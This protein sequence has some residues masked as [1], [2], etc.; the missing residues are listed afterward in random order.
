MQ[1]ITLRAAFLHCATVRIAHGNPQKK[2]EKKK[3]GNTESTNSI[4]TIADKLQKEEG[5]R[6]QGE[7][8]IENMHSAVCYAPQ[9]SFSRRR[10]EGTFGSGKSKTYATNVTIPHLRG[11]VELQSAV[12]K[13]PK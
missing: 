12:S 4:T 3:S 2:E 9:N 5:K 7:G 8:R 1:L 13:A 10:F 11:I 6:P